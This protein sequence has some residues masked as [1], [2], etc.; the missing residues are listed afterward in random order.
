M[1]LIFVNDV[2]ILPFDRKYE[3]IKYIL[4]KVYALSAIH[5]QLIKTKKTVLIHCTYPQHSFAY[6]STN[7]ISELKKQKQNK[8][9]TRHFIQT[10][11]K[12]VPTIKLRKSA[13]NSE[14]K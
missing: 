12:K 9:I 14:I 1:A 10:K 4:F 8:K 5:S 11:M 13:S 7:P 6:G 3:C 2:A